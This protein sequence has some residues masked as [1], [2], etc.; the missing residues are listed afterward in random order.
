M[1]FACAM[2]KPETGTNVY[3][4]KILDPDGFEIELTQRKGGIYS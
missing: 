4:A 1:R 3:V 2:I